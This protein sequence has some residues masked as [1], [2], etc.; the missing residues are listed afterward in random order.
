MCAQMD[1][2]QVHLLTLVTPQV[3]R[4]ESRV[5]ELELHRDHA[6]PSE[7]SPGHLQALAQEL[8]Q[9]ARGQGHCNHRIL[10]VTMSTWRVW[11]GGSQVGVQ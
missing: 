5:L 2:E 1:V 8:E 4:L 9:K 10:Q 7:T 6:A 11:L 3:L